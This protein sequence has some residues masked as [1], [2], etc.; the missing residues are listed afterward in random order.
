MGN[1]GLTGPAPYF[2]EEALFPEGV[3]Y[4]RWS[5]D[6]ELTVFTLEK[7]LDQG[8]TASLQ[9]EGQQVVGHYKQ[10]TVLVISLLK[11]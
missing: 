3:G 7:R 10:M 6:G 8:A 1:R 5:S 11:H 9:T 2:L 4:L